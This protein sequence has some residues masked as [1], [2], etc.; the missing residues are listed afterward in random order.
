MKNNITCLLLDGLG[1]HIDDHKSRKVLN[2]LL[3]MH[4]IHVSICL[5]LAS[6]YLYMCFVCCAFVYVCI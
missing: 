1:K 6:M 4:Q 5:I 3:Q 2:F